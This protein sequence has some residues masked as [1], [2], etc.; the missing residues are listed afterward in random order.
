MALTHTVG[1]AMLQGI[2]TS[3]RPFVRTPKCADQPALMQ[4]FIMAR[5]EIFWMAAL[6]GCA[7]LVLWNFTPQNQ[8]ALVWSLSVLVQSL[9]F[10]AA[11][12]TSMCNAVPKLF[13]G[14]AEAAAAPAAGAASAAE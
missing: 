11:L 2:F 4:G 3:G 12:I 13:G 10:A 5:D 1:R 8:E 6:T 9:P 14:G 7:F